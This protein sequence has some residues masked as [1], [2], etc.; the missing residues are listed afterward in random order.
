MILSKNTIFNFEDNNH[1]KFTRI[2]IYR[3]GAIKHTP[4][5]IHGLRYFSDL[6]PVDL[7]PVGS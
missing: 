2:S 4:D 6:G 3:K 5:K 1:R 7:G